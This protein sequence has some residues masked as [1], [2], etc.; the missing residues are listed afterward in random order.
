GARGHLLPAP[1][2][3]PH[4]GERPPGHRP[5]PAGRGGRV[6]RRGVRTRP[7][8]PGQGARVRG[9]G[10][11][12]TM[13]TDA[14]ARPDAAG[15]VG[16]YGGRFVPEILMEPLRELEAAYA[17]ARRDPAFQAELARHLRDFVGRPTP[18]TAAERLSARL[19]ARVF[20]KREDLCH[21][22]AHKINNAL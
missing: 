3:W 17:A 13:S 7:Q 9:R 18:V 19:G 5:G 21:T 10:E 12:A 2:R 1:G 20:L 15:R 22:G 16:T 4:A 6:E 8:G 11:G 14:S